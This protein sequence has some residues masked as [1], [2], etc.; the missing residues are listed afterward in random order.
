MRG[1]LTALALWFCALIPALAQDTGRL[2]LVGVMRTGAAANN[3]PFATLFREELATL[4]GFGSRVLFY[5]SFRELLT[6]TPT[7]RPAVATALLRCG[8]WL[9]GRA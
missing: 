6:A 9:M 4:G 1:A 5:A 2:P 3:E 7:P 8:S